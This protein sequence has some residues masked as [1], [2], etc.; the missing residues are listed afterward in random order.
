M[1]KK[2]VVLGVM[3]VAVFIG[4]A[5]V[6]HR[7][8]TQSVYAGKDSE[9]GAPAAGHKVAVEVI[10]PREAAQSEG[11][12]Y[13]ATL[14]AGEEGLLSS[15]NGGKVVSVLFDDGKPVSQGEPLVLLDDQDIKNQLKSAASQLEAAKASLLK[16]E[17][18]L[19][20]SQR[21]YERL[22]TLAEQGAAAP[23]ELENA[24][25]ALKMAQADAAS[26]RAAIQT[27]QTNFDNLQ[28]TLAD[29]VVRAPISGIMDGKNVSIGQFLTP[30]SVLG[31]VK[32]I[33]SLDAAIEVDQG[34]IEGIKVGQKAGIK[35]D[36]KQGVYEG[37]VKS[38]SPSADPSSRAFKVKIEL[39]NRDLSLKPGIF[40]KVVP[41]QEGRGKNL[42][43]PVALIMGSEGNYYVYINDKGIVKKRA[44]TVGN[45]INNQAEIP[46]GLQENDAVIST[47]LNMLQE[48][49]EIT[50]ASE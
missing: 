48:G 42:V 38:I 11:P 40:A 7:F 15:K 50:V 14:E 33:S 2:R 24:E 12:N 4:G 3:I 20:N 13:K 10:T 6:F 18:G 44:V 16:I 34:L 1:S 23:V 30:G 8:E 25:T 32:D 9:S 43:I 26:G 28:S 27:A 19:E 45:L 35:L 21:S 47:N 37:V 39:N 29:M 17:A 49:D 36:D 41:A 22:K 5:A 31:R 46:S